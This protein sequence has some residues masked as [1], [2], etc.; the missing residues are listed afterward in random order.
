[1]IGHRRLIYL[2]PIE[3]AKHLLIWCRLVKSLTDSQLKEIKT[4]RSYHVC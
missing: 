3:N 1:M 2:V 4:Y